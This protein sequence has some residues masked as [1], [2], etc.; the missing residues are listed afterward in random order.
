MV[1]ELL[2]EPL[3]EILAQRLTALRLAQQMDN[4][5]DLR[6]AI[7]SLHQLLLD[8]HIQWF[9]AHSLTEWYHAVIILAQHGADDIG[10][11]LEGKALAALW[12]QDA[13]M[14]ELIP[15]LYWVEAMVVAVAELFPAIIVLIELFEIRDLWLLVVDGQGIQMLPNLCRG[16]KLLVLLQPLLIFVKGS[17]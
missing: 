8:A 1:A 12:W 3:I 7:S 9:L 6:S 16:W 15:H 17:L 13:S 5:G 10:Y 4:L 11:Q 2:E 14:A